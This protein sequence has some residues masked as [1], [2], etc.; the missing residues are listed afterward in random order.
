MIGG[1]ENG[2][3]EKYWL[4][5]VLEGT[6]WATE[7]PRNLLQETEEEAKCPEACRAPSAL[8]PPVTHMA[9]SGEG[10][11]AHALLPQGAPQLLIL[12]HGR[13]K[14]PGSLFLPVS[15]TYQRFLN[16][17]PAPHTGLLIPLGH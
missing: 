14:K 6:P 16:R 1:R 7:L 5:R 8:W 2:E 15:S 11:L 4:V 17:L 9:P 10:W 12:G 13:W 3:V